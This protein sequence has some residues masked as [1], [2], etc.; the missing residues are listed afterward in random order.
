MG[1]AAAL[2]VQRAALK[3]TANFSDYQDPGFLEAN[4]IM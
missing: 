1:Q 2:G 3:I 4:G